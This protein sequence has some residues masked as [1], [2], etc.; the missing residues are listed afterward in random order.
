MS[1]RC[2]V[3]GKYAELKR[4]DG[5]VTSPESIR[6]SRKAK[7]NGKRRVTQDSNYKVCLQRSQN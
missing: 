1:N 5:K 3:K 7:L 6:F 2:L 4:Q